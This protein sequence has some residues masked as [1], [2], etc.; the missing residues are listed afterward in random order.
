[1]DDAMQKSSPVGLGAAVVGTLVP[2]GSFVV[3]GCGVV[4]GAW[5]GVVEISGGMGAGVGG[6]TG[7]DEKWWRDEFRNIKSYYIHCR[8][9]PMLNRETFK[10]RAL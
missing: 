5:P 6:A 7:A 3:T 1:M 4:T 10:Q 9:Y 2:I 8:I